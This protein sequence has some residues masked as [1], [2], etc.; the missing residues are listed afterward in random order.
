MI[1]KLLDSKIENKI[2]DQDLNE[3]RNI[4][5]SRKLQSVAKGHLM[6]LRKK[7]FVEVKRD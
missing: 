4:I 3:A 5:F 6:D 2:N 7:A 1:F